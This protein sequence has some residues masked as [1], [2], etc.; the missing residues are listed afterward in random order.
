LMTGGEARIS[1]SHFDSNTAATTGGA[2]DMQGGGTITG[3][4]FISNTATTRGG[5]V[6]LNSAAT[7]NN[8][9]LQGNRTTQSG[10]GSDFGGGA[11]SNNF[12]DGTISDSTFTGNTSAGDGGG[13]NTAYGV[14]QLYNTTF[15]NNIAVNGGAVHN[16]NG[17]TLRVYNS[18]LSAN[19]ATNGGGIYNTDA[20]S[21]V[22]IT[23]TYLYSNT[24]NTNGGALY[25]ASGSG[26][27][28][29]ASVL[30]AGNQAGTNGA[31]IYAAAN[32]QVLQATIVSPTLGTGTALYVIGGMA[33]ITDTIVA[34]YT[35]GLQNAGGTV[36]AD[37]NLFFNNT[38]NK[39]GTIGGGTHDVIG[40]DPLFVDPVGGDYRVRGGSPALAKGVDAGVPMDIVDDSRNFPSTL[41]AY[42][43]PVVDSANNAYLLN[44]QV[45]QATLVPHFSAPRLSY[46]ASVSREIVSTIVTPTATVAGAAITVNG[47]PIASGTPS[48]VINLIIGVN[49]ITVVVTAPDS[50]TVQTYTVALT[51]RPW[52]GPFYVDQATGSD[53]N[54][55][56]AWGA[57]HACQTIGG[58]IGKSTQ[59]GTYIYIAAGLYTEN[60]TATLPL[61]FVGVGADNTIIDGNQ[62]NRVLNITGAESAVSLTGLTVR[63]GKLTSGNGAGI[64]AAG[65]LAL[66]NVNVLSNTTSSGNGG[67]VYAAGTLSLTNTT[68]M[69]NTAA[70]ATASVYGGGIYA[71]NVTRISGGIFRNNLANA[72]SATAGV[73]GGGAYVSNWLLTI[74]GAQF[75]SNTALGNI[76]SANGASNMCYGGGL[77]TDANTLL[78]NTD[79]I[80]NTAKCGYDV[81]GGGVWA[82]N[83]A[84]VQGGLFEGNRTEGTSPS[85]YG[86]VYGGGLHADGVLVITDTRFIRNIG[87]SLST[88]DAPQGGALSGLWNTTITGALFQENIAKY[89]GAAYFRYTSATIS[90]TQFIS[91]STNSIGGAIGQYAAS[92]TV[93]NSKFIGNSASANGGATFALSHFA[94]GSSNSKFVNTLFVNNT[95]GDGAVFFNRD[96]SQLSTIEF[97][98]TT[99]VASTLQGS[100][101]AL[102][103]GTPSSMSLKDSIVVNY[104]NALNADVSGRSTSDYNM[105]Y[106]SAL[107]S[108]IVTGT[109]DIGNTDPLFINPAQ[110]EYHLSILSPAIGKGITITGV[111]FDLD[112][113]PRVN[114]PTLGAYE[115]YLEL[116]DVSLSSLT[117]SSG[118][119]NPTFTP[120]DTVY[121]A[122]VPYS[123]ATLTLTPTTSSPAPT[124]T[125]NSQVVVS[126]TE[127]QPIPLLVGPNSITVTVI[128]TDTITTKTYRVTVTRTGA[129]LANLELSSGPLSPTFTRDTT[130]YTA[131][132]SNLVTSVTVKP[133]LADSTATIT[134]NG[135]PVSSGASSGPIA[136]SVGANP[137]SIVV[138]A[139]D[140][141]TIK[142]YTIT[143]TRPP[144]SDA[145][146]ISLVVSNSTLTPAFATDTLDYATT[147]PNGITAVI[148]T[149]TSR[150]ANAV[151]KVN[152]VIVASGASSSPIGLA[153]GPNTLTTFVTAQDGLATQTY[154]VVVTRSAAL[155]NSAALANLVLSHGPLT[156][157]FA[158]GTINYTATVPF[159]VAEITVTPTTGELTATMTVNGAPV[160]SGTPS[161]LISMTIG[162]NTI[163]TVVTAPDGVTQ[164]TYAVIVTRRPWEGPFYVD[165]QTGSDSNIC[166]AW[167]SGRACKTIGGA[168][169]KATLAGAT[170]YI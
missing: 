113:K 35:T 97:Q 17:G 13:L 32:T 120:T 133:T 59:P 157:V 102:R 153:V 83:V 55:C 119:L 9:L 94:I 46:T 95:S 108:G 148:V 151:I 57:G 87:V 136:L 169:G 101:V 88:Y 126:G 16:N 144:S 30:L 155:L 56:E 24:A 74:S 98:Y 167:G 170:V 66:T 75:I 18:A 130:S 140:G 41:G 163:T 67:G 7:L 91:N 129:D 122:R 160:T 14:M 110:N 109:H 12:N 11:V 92:I 50:T 96:S 70:H 100:A 69:S 112:G 71:A 142:T 135:T 81:R 123:I 72:A 124:I 29:V 127:S 48:G 63:N 79:F 2:I 65:A 38:T 36:I 146:L 37:Y 128:A 161:G 3:G 43:L 42:E 99:I 52:E 111:T 78:V 47:T 90:N 31:A 25:V 138:A 121:T 131:T 125:V 145:N 61:N 33:G 68:V 143:V 45:R 150:E 114:P 49:P 165:G 141:T 8:V 107:S 51:R 44:L 73:Y 85:P 164:R 116:Y 84:Q 53:S 76:N 156:P 60:L 132:V 10:S 62:T 106:N 34:S 162:A 21:T 89:G 139:Q 80:S 1:A 152:N 39:T 82:G 27:A 118:T 19:R 149:P 168:I 6:F 166:D 86:A 103:T 77:E 40:S 15:T 134:I 154:T 117:L 26:S 5:A 137:I 22:G 115:G 159:T 28:R 54:E 93:Y 4:E 104:P 20:N 23:S 147:V 58:A 158:A 105:F 64:N